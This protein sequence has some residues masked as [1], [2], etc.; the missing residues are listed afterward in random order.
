MVD[1]HSQVR[2]L[3]D[4]DGNRVNEAGPSIPV[5]VNY[6]LLML[7]YKLSDFFILQ[8]NYLIM[9]CAYIG[10]RATVRLLEAASC[11]FSDLF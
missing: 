11:A 10:S 7:Y 6:Y 4:D 8:V 2:A 5:Q 1:S 9:I 3:F